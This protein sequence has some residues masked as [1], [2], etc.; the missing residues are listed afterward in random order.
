VGLLI[1]R[2]LNGVG[3][4]RRCG[5][6]YLATACGS[7]RVAADICGSESAA[8]YSAE[9]AASVTVELGAG[10]VLVVLLSLPQ[11]IMAAVPALSPVPREISCGRGFAGK[12]F[13]DLVTHRRIALNVRSLHRLDLR[14]TR[15]CF[16]TSQLANG[17]TSDS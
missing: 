8:R 1:V 9:V 11:P 5:E 17:A 10:V 15:G 6:G 12:Y 7:G 2:D 14:L 13:A 4:D 16:V 3:L